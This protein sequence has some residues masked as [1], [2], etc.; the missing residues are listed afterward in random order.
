MNEQVTA[1][2]ASYNLDTPGGISR[3][4]LLSSENF[5]LLPRL[6]GTCLSQNNQVKIHKRKKILIFLRDM[7]N[8]MEGRYV[9][10]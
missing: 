6:T 1:A 3:T 9:T 7:P 5:F 10:R 2:A 4:L 8:E